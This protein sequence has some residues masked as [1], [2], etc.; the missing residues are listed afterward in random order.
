MEVWRLED[1]SV[2]KIVKHP[3]S[4]HPGIKRSRELQVSA[5][6]L[7]LVQLPFIFV[8][9]DESVLVDA[10]SELPRLRRLT[11]CL[12]YVTDR[13]VAEHCSN[14]CEL[15]LSGRNVTNEYLL[16]GG[17]LAATYAAL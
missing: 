11:L 10:L 1:D 15:K 6:K 12:R 16:A 9:K 2:E 3:F 5:M 4:G 13:A 17:M 14:P 7:S 8:L